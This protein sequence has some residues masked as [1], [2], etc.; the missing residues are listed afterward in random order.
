MKKNT[1]Y[2]I[3]LLVLM[4]ISIFYYLKHNNILFATG[5]EYELLNIDDT[6]AVQKIIIQDQ[7]G[8]LTLKRE[9]YKWTANN[10]VPVNPSSIAFFLRA[11]KNISLNAPA[12]QEQ[13]KAANAHAAPIKLKMELK[14]SPNRSIVIAGATENE[15]GTYMKLEGSEK[16]YVMN[17]PG[18]VGNFTSI[19]ITDVAA[20]S[21]N[22][23]MSFLPD[24]IDFISVKDIRTP[25]NSFSIEKSKDSY[26]LKDFEGKEIQSPCLRQ[27]VEQYLTYF[28]RIE[29]W[30]VAEGLKTNGVEEIIKTEGDYFVEVKG[31][32]MSQSFHQFPILQQDA[33]GQTSLDLDNAYIQINKQNKLVLVKYVQTDAI[34]KRVSY[35]TKCN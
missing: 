31:K 30:G 21:D 13:T 26:I 6:A 25:E 19:F 9:G 11:L 8:V 10:A 7:Y 20:W 32:G 29:Y 2:S 23:V 16:V 12:S 24:D 4:V 35:F 17:I 18:I 1:K 14:N 5:N 28:I 34:T 22:T 33:N 3:V 15:T 27:K